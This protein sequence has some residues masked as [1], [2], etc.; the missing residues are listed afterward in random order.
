MRIVAWNIRAGGGRRVADRATRARAGARRGR[1]RISCDQPSRGASPLAGGARLC[2]SSR[3]RSPRAGINALASAA[4]WPLRRV[5]SAPRARS[6]PLA[7]TCVDAPV[8]SVGPCTGTTCERPQ[9]RSRR[10]AGLRA[11]VAAGKPPS[12]R[13]TKSG[14]HDR[15]SHRLQRARGGRIERRSGGWHTHFAHA[16]EQRVYPYSP[17]AARLTDRS[18]VRER[19][20]LR[21]EGR[22][23]YGGASRRRRRDCLS[24]HAAL[25]VDLLD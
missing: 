14:A 18:G 23:T 15:E 22:A 17:T 19:S 10:R 1:C 24:D 4:R 9:D 16:S 8:R 2:I 6:V 20:A 7:V 12:W 13:S 25:L 11:A 3:R 5:G 21:A